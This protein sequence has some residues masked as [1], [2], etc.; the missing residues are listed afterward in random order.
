MFF[1]ASRKRFL[2]AVMRRVSPPASLS[3]PSII[4]DSDSN[5]SSGSSSSSSSSS[6]SGSSSSY[7]TPPTPLRAVSVE[8]MDWAT[9]GTTAAAVTGK[10]PVPPSPPLPP[11]AALTHASL[12][13]SLRLLYMHPLTHMHTHAFTCDEILWQL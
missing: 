5:S 12:R 6:S 4:A 3:P 8:Q 2:G 13:Q 9:A 11:S 7:G 10:P 1:G